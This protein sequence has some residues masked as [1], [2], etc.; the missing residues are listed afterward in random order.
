M[1]IASEEAEWYALHRYVGRTHI[2]YRDGRS[3]VLPDFPQ[4]ITYRREGYIAGR[5]AEST[6]AEVRAA[7]ACQVFCVRGVFGGYR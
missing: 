7:G 2:E 6:E 3:E 4:K 5:T 1:S